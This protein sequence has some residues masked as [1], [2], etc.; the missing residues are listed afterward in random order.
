[1][2]PLRKLRESG[3]PTAD[4]VSELLAESV[5]FNS[6]ILIRQSLEVIVDNEEQLILG[7]TG[8]KLNFVN[9]LP[10]LNAS[11]RPPPSLEVAFT[12]DAGRSRKMSR[13]RSLDQK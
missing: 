2:H 13:H 12:T 5:V 1:V 10:N 8:V 11:V 3:K 7:T 4:Q 9:W 6:P